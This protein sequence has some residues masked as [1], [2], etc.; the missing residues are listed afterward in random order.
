M[1]EYVIMEYLE[2][3]VTRC[4]RWTGNREF[5]WNGLTVL[6]PT[7]TFYN[8]MFATWYTS[9]DHVHKCVATGN[10]CTATNLQLHIYLPFT[11]LAMVL[12]ILALKPVGSRHANSHALGVSLTLWLV[13]SRSHA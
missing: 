12:H 10:S 1:E 13:I 4:E 2:L 3:T 7:Q 6:P 11:M 8:F 5:I 9:N